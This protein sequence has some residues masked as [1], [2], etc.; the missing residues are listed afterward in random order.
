M[1]RLVSFFRVFA[2]LQ[3]VKFSDVKNEK[4]LVQALQNFRISLQLFCRPLNM[5]MTMT[6]K[7]KVLFVGNL[8]K[9]LP[10][11]RAFEEKFECISYQLSTVEQL[12]VDF[13][14]KFKDIEAIYGAWLGFFP[15]GGF[16]NQILAAAPKNLKVISIC[17]VGH[18]GYDGPGLKKKGIVL[19]NVP[20]TGAAEPVADLVLYNAITSFRQFHVYPG[21]FNLS[22]NH[23]L[24]VRKMLDNST[25]FDQVTGTA[26][27]GDKRGYSYGEYI[28]NRPLMSPRGHN[29]VIVGFGNIGQTI[30][31]KL[32]DLGMN[33]HYVKRT[34]LSPSQIEELGYPVT[35]H[36][37]MSDATSVADLVVIACP[38]TPQTKHLISREIISQIPNPF[39]IINI[40]RGLIIDEDALVDGLKLGKILFA[41]LDVFEKEPFAHPELFGRQD[42]VLT[43]HIGASTIENFDYTAVMAM[44]NIEDVLLQGGKGLTPVN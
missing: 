22:N 13:E 12:L 33:I 19:T 44:S 4:F 42:V 18:D 28:N 37:T 2:P 39:R 29:V 16:Y 40:G 14:T 26:T 32:S 17:S 20:L 1:D 31:K 5:T 9:D 43:P 35:F 36:P 24:Q 25:T 27:Q 3:M 15:F 11:Y 7:P 6:S 21:H 41:G 10:E 34:E 30:G 8:N 23:T 38:A